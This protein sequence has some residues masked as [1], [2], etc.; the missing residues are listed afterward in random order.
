MTTKKHSYGKSY[1]ESIN[2]IDFL[3]LNE[4]DHYK[5]GYAA[6]KLFVEAKNGL[7]TF[8]KNPLTQ[9]VLCALDCFKKRRM[10]EVRVPKQYQE[11]LRG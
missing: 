3:Y 9:M 2:G 6:G 1:I 10:E 5:T 4:D 11:E 8:F 7:I